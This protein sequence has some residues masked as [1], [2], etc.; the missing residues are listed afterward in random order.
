MDKVIK[1]DNKKVI[2][3]AIVEMEDQSVN[4]VYLA[5]TRLESLPKEQRRPDY[6]VI[7]QY[8]EQYILTHCQHK[9]VKDWIDIDPDRGQMIEYCEHCYSTFSG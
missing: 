7:I 6:S 4:L 9:R 1:K 8:M 3:K 2:K 5:K